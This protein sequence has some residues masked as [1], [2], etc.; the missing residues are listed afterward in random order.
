MVDRRKLLGGMLALPFAGRAL[1]QALALPLT[2]ACG[3]PPALTARQT[4]GPYYTPNTPKRDNFVEPGAKAERL[5]L[6]GFVLSTRCTGVAQAMLDVWHCDENGVY[7][8]TGYRYRGHLFSDAH[9]RYRLET[10]V[11]AVYPGRA[12]HI[13]LRVQA[14]GR[15]ML[16]TQVYFP[17]DPGN[18]RDWIWKRELEIRREGGRGRFDFVVDA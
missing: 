1:A 12:R 13:H 7:D 5:V 14:P 9:G 11:P 3:K 18:E 10:I 16:T 4:A 8:N 6:E 15:R 2:P 17:G